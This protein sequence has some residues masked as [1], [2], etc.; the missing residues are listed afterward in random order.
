MEWISKRNQLRNPGSLAPALLIALSMAA[1]L[2]A[3]TPTLSKEYIRLGE[4]FIAIENCLPVL[5]GVPAYDD[6]AHSGTIS[7]TINP[8]CSW[9]VSGLLSWITIT[10]GA[11]GIGDGTISYYVYPNGTNADRSATLSVAGQTFTVTQYTP[12]R[13]ITVAPCRVFDTRNATGPFGGPP[14]AGGTARSFPVTS[15]SC[16]PS[17]SGALAYSVNVTVIPS[18][19]LGYLTVWPSGLEQPVVSLLNSFDGRVKANAA[20]VA[21]G[22]SGAVSVYASATT[23]T[24]VAMDI[25][26]YFVPSSTAGSLTYYPVTPCR[27]ADTRQATGPLGAP[28]MTAGQTR[29]FPLLSGTCGI[30]S[31]AQ[32][33]SL[34]FT[35]IPLGQ[36][37]YISVWPAGQGQPTVSTLND[38][39]GR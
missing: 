2:Q 39:T 15:S 16:L 25:N 4:R 11:S 21:A 9:S 34:N 10:S 27:L 35:A 19:T 24:N 3:Q 36:L 31:A 22:T 20:I 18:G 30:P 23:S 8:G 26:G 13:F 32:A 14:I 33:Y 28:E 37:P 7:V 17:S 6:Y 1:V 12:M 29:T 5:S 38:L